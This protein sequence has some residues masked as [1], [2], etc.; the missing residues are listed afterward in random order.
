MLL[1]VADF[2]GVSKASA[3]RIVRDVS[4]SIS[5]LYGKY[6]Y[7][8]TNTGQ[9]F[10]NISRFPRVLGALDGTHIRI[11][12]PLTFYVSWLSLFNRPFL[13][14][15]LKWVKNLETGMI[16]FRLMCKL[17][18]ML[19]C[20]WWMGLTIDD[21]LTFNSHAANACRKALNF[22]KQLSRAARVSWGLHLEII[23][24]IYTAVIEPMIL[25]AASAWASTTHKIGIP[26]TV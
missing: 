16:T 6:I 25:Y 1:S 15:V 5:Q 11:Q 9:D 7:M 18:V 13:L 2:V 3:C 22:Y 10:Y 19:I 17:C 4:F 12:S 26:P 20:Y 8:R 21:K 23:R 24:T 14:Q